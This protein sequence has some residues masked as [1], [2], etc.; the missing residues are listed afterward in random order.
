[1]N[2]ISDKGQPGE[3]QPTLGT[4]PTYSQQCRPNSDSGHTDSEQPELG[5]PTPHNTG[6][7]LQEPQI[8]KT[9]VDWLGK[10]PRTLD[11][12]AEGVEL[13]HCSTSSLKTTLLLSEVRLSVRTLVSSTPE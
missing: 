6:D 5:G 11:D 7:P 1:M 9:H 8:H 2:R 12:P 10:L 4:S 13:V 3:V